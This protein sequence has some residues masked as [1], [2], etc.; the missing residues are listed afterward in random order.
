[1]GK[2][3]VNL[4]NKPLGE[5]LETGLDRG[6][7]VSNIFIDFKNKQIVVEYDKVLY[8]PTG[9]VVQIIETKNYKRFNSTTN[10]K[11]DALEQSQ[12]GQMIKGLLENDLSLIKS[13]E[14][15]EQDLKQL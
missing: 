12:I 3:I 4:Q 5:D 15:I 8:A 7:E 11:F 2:A 10:N 14:T 13:F 1:M 6:I 9:V